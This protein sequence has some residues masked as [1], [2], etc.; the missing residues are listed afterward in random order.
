M[1][2]GIL[3]A[4]P[5][6]PFFDEILNDLKTIASAPASTHQDSIDFR[7]PQVHALNCLKDA[8]M[9]SRLGPATEA[10]LSATLII[11][12]ECLESEMSVPSPLTCAE[13]LTPAA[14]GQF[15]TVA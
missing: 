6:D 1:V 7:L 11:A 3:G 10:H 9:N 13:E 15:E 14:V 2:T 5:S 8:F 12:A 4:F